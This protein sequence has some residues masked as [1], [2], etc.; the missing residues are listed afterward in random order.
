[1]F[2]GACRFSICLGAVRTLFRICL[3]LLFCYPTFT[4]GCLH[5]GDVAYAFQVEGRTVRSVFQQILFCFLAACQAMYSSCAH[6]RR[7]RMFVGFNEDSC[8][9]A[10]IATICFLFSD[11]HEKSA[12]SRI[13]FQFARST[14]GLT[15][16]TARTFGVAPL[17]FN[18]RYIGD[19]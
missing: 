6:V 17:P 5:R 2:I 15:N 18:V 3:R 9:E 14:R 10:K 13:T 8:N 11:G 1:M 19:R 7:A 4:R 12:F 16:V